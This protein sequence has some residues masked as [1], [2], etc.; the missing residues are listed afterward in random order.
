MPSVRASPVLRARA[1]REGALAA[2]SPAHARCLGVLE[3]IRDALPGARLWGDSTEPVY[4]GNLLFEPSGPG[5]WANSST[6]YGTLGWAVPAACG[7]ALADPSR[8]VVA[9]VGDGGLQFHLAE[10]GTLRD[11]GARV[12]VL[13]WNNAGY[14]EIEMAMA[15]AGVPPVGVLPSAPDLVAVARAC[16]LPA[17]RPGALAELPGLL[18]EA[19]ARAP[20]LIDLPAGL[21]HG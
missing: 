19:A 3:T 18:R 10:L 14:R 5:L 8:P 7:A 6:G 16:G 12:V 4:A 1:A 20:A 11:E 17:W 9:L 2:L 21:V 15:E 13:A